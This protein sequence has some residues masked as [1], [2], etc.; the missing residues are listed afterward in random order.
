MTDYPEKLRDLIATLGVLDER[1][2]RIDMLID[3]AGRFR[4]VPEE[5]ARRPY[6]DSHKVPG[7]ESQAYLFAEPRP[8]HTLDLHFAVENP[9]GVSAMALAVILE[10]TLSG[11]PPEL[12][13]QVPGEIV[14]DLF[15]RQLS[16]GKSMGL[17]GMVNMVTT[18]ARQHAAGGRE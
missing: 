5:I 15:G 14:Y 10:E 1:T 7:C 9:Q 8:D 11:A 17:M 3:I 2:D 18:T 6:P 13:A 12:V 16:M 4:G